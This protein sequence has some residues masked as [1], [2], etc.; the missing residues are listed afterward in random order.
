M[1]QTEIPP[2]TPLVILE[3]IEEKLAQKTGKHTGT[4]INHVL[5]IARRNK[6]GRLNPEPLSRKHQECVGHEKYAAVL[7]GA[8]ARKAARNR[9]KTHLQKGR[10]TLLSRFAL[11]DEPEIY[12][13][14]FISRG[15][16][17]KIPIETGTTK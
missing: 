4:T 2:G 15:N 11:A 6:A 3:I 16:L 13:T 10:A 7:T 8:Q 14:E 17:P 1:K 12:H 5:C 9:Y